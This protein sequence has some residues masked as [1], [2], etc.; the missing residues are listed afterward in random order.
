MVDADEAKAAAECSRASKG[1][2]P[3]GPQC[4]AAEQRADN[5]QQR[6]QAARDAVAQAGV[7]PKDSQA[8]RLAAI[9]PVSEEAVALYQPIVLPVAISVLGL[10]LVSAGAHNS[11]KPVKAPRRKGRKPRKRLGPRKSKPAAAP[12]KGTVL[13]FVR[14]ASTRARPGIAPRPGSFLVDFHS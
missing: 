3:R 12:K 1:A 14:K 10:L 2:D 8:V 9:L 6:L 13:P 11:P 7:V 5:G 4:R